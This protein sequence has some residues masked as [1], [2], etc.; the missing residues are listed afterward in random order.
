MGELTWSF[1][2]AEAFDLRPIGSVDLGGVS[3]DIPP[4]TKGR[5]DRFLSFDMGQV[6]T[7]ALAGAGVRIDSQDV[8]ADVR[9]VARSS[10]KFRKRGFFERM[11][12][13]LIGRPSRYDYDARDAAFVPPAFVKKALA[14]LYDVVAVLI[15]GIPRDRWCEWAGPFELLGITETF[16]LYHDWR[17][18]AARSGLTLEAIKNFDPNEEQCSVEDGLVSYCVLV[19]GHTEAGL[20]DTRLEG[21]YRLMAAGNEYVARRNAQQ[22]RAVTGEPDPM[23]LASIDIFGNVADSDERQRILKYWGDRDAAAKEP[24]P[25]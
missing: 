17:Y 10:V 22:A 5:F 14:D 24:Q 13:R 11:W 4:L 8:V 1:S 23:P 3:Y 15:P 7:L 21:F 9:A 20:L 18:I 19:P 6:M 25:S 2:T 12:F 16:R